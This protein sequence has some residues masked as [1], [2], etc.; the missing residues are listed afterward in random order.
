MY[1]ILYIYKKKNILAVSL[2]DIQYYIYPP[3][4]R[5]DLPLVSRPAS[6]HVFPAAES[7]PPFAGTPETEERS[8]LKTS[9]D[10]QRAQSGDRP[11][12]PEAEA[13]PVRCSAAENGRRSGSKRYGAT[14]GT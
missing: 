9:G 11:A 13:V 7:E 8:S 5:Y 6:Q 14:D 4:L 1:I 2:Y 10:F 3:H 12:T